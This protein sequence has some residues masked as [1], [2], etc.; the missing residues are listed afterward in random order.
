M[1]T[2][3]SFAAATCL[4]AMLLTGLVSSGQPRLQKNGAA[5]QLMVEGKPFLVLGAELHNS[6]SSSLDYMAP[7]WQPLQ[8]MNLN[9]VLAAVSWQLTEPQENKWDFSHVDGI[10]KGAR[11]HGLKV[12]LLWF[13]SWKNGLSHYTPA[14][15]KQDGRRFPRVRLSNGKPTETITALSAEAA[16]AD[17][18]AF[19][20]LL[21][22]VKEVDAQQQTVI[23]VQVENEAG[24]IGDTRDHSEAANALFAKPVPAELLKGLMDTRNEWQPALKKHWEEAG[25]KT[26]GSWTELFGQ[27][28]F[29]DEA[30][31]AWQYARYM[32]QVAAA[33]K[34][35][36][37]L[38]MFVN[39][40]VVQPEDRLPGDYPAGGPQAQVHDIWRIGAPSVDI[41]APDIYLPAF[42][43]IAALYHHSW[44]PLFVPE[45]FTGDAGTA[46]AFYAIGQHNAIGYS[47]FG[48]DAKESAAGNAVIAKAY[49]VL[50]QL[51]PDI[52][53]AQTQN[54]V[55][56]VALS[57]KDSVQSLE[58]GGYRL[59]VTLRK[60]WSGIAQATKGYALVIHTGKD[61]F[62][63]AGADT[64]ILFLPASPGPAMAGL[65]SVYEGAYENGVWKA[66]RLLNG[67]DIMMSYK[68]AG[69]AAAN[70]TGTGVRLRSE[71][72][73]MKVKLYRFE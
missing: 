33:G 56:A 65:L 34:A 6:S 35:A 54:A 68:L 36:Y 67:D 9:T 47:P 64:D 25:S 32:N 73:I 66:G 55:R 44:N 2:I 24:V 10:L 13:G 4:A 50:A 26:R 31:M 16:G 21:R 58:L 29:A 5:T 57:G 7:L 22:H 23:M 40:W 14:W 61:E 15:V 37:N 42:K 30:F 41:K 51:S 53:A 45:S 49:H 46:N 72:G 12:V 18:K 20:A 71:P 52:L 38:P 59:L 62:T 48:I 3:V 17:A 8:Q 11:E 60:S 1:K 43:E 28:P 69:E 63:V 19:A 27:T 39:T 70:R